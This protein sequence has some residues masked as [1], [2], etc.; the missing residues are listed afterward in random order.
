MLFFRLCPVATKHLGDCLRNRHD[1][2]ETSGTAEPPRNAGSSIVDAPRNDRRDIPSKTR[3]GLSTK[4][5]S[6][7]T[8]VTVHDIRSQLVLDEL[9][10]AVAKRIGKS[11]SPA[12]SRSQPLTN[13]GGA[14]GRIDD[15]SYRA[16]KQAGCQ[17]APRSHVRP[18]IDVQHLLRARRTGDGPFQ[19]ARHSSGFWTGAQNRDRRA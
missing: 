15:V 18:R 1:F 9:V 4:E 8:T 6:T 7:S 11:K 3:G 17:V 12:Q 14:C 13:P 5:I 10:G 2:V 16:D 19:R